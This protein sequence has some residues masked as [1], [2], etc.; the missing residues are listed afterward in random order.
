MA[1]EGAQGHHFYLA[2]AEDTQGFGRAM[3]AAAN[4]GGEQPLVI[5]L[6]GDLG[7]GKTTLSQG[8]IRAAGHTGAVKSPTYTLVE[9]YENLATPVYHFDLYRLADPEELEF[10]GFRDY[11]EKRC[12]LLIEWPKKGEGFLP[13]ADITIN[14]RV[15]KR[16]QNQVTSVGRQAS[17]VP[18]SPRGDQLLQTLL[19]LWQNQ[20]KA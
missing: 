15:A 20:N 11:L 17:I 1:S 7:A 6:Q 5:F 19:G 4:D 14:V 2:N 18:A 12:I 10:L 13:P 9:P 3:A 8:F 16:E